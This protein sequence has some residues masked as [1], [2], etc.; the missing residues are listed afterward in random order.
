MSQDTQMNTVKAAQ[1][2]NVI[3]IN[4]Y[5]TNIFNLI[6]TADHN[7]KPHAKAEPKAKIDTENV[8]APSRSNSTSTESHSPSNSA[9]N[10]Y[11]FQTQDS[12]KRDKLDFLD[13]PVF[14]RL[15][16]PAIKS[17]DFL[18]PQ[19]YQDPELTI[20]AGYC[21]IVLALISSVF[22]SFW[23]FGAKFLPVTGNPVI[24]FMREDY[25]YCVVLPLLYPVF[26]IFIYKN[27]VSMKAFRHV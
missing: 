16:A 25:H 6:S 5:N 26:Y 9:T 7:T 17:V 13:S 20:L 21:T 15:E 4:N 1:A 22:L 2:Y 12:L 8:R 23:M 11:R 3:N 27:W 18:T 10:L 24:D 14:V 19:K